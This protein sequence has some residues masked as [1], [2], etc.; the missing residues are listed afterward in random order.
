MGPRPLKIFFSS[1]EIALKFIS[2]F[3]IKARDLP[4]NSTDR[5]ITVTHDRTP[6]ERELI[7]LVYAD[8]DNHEKSGETNIMIKFK[9]EFPSIVPF[10]RLY[11][12][13]H[14]YLS[15]AHSNQSKN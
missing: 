6:R 7:R 3:N 1:K 5:A 4:T 15:N 9:D 12:A 14:L 8:L 10:S 2:D 13:T 11:Q